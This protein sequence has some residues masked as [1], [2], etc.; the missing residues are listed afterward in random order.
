MSIRHPRSL[1]WRLVTWVAAAQGAMFALLILAMTGVVGALWMRGSISSGIY[2]RS[3]IEALTEAV[4][5]GARGELI[6]RPAPELERLRREIQGF[7]FIVRDSQG[8]EVTEGQAP[9]ELTPL[10][11]GLDTVESAVLRGN[12]GD[13]APSLAI[14]QWIDTAAGRVQMLTGGQGRLLLHQVVA[15]FLPMLYLTLLIIGLMTVATFLVTPFVV[16]RA[17]AGLGRVA[18]EAKRIDITRSGTRLPAVGVPV[19]IVPLVNAV[20]GAL[21]RLDRGYEGHKRFLADAAHELRTPIAILT[22]RISA[23]QPGPEKIR[24]LED[25]TRLTVLT[26]QLLDLQRLD[27]EQASFAPVDLVALAE[28]SVLDL[29]PLAFTAGYEMS[30]EA[31]TGEIRVDGDETALDRALMNLIQNAIDHGGRRGTIAVRVAKAGWIEVCDDG[32]GIPPDQR[33][34]IFEPFHRLRQGGR[35]AGLG[36]DLVRRIMGLHGGRVEVVAGSSAGACIHLIFPRQ[37]SS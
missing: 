3:T 16:Q 5:R 11:K 31:E 9:A 35:G 4:G 17:L 10:M 14:V 26:G 2:E 6:L 30:F 36:L 8:R 1:K 37:R 13:D 19:E 25:M 18:D 20:N 23:L 21:A 32:D 7:W 29:A 24:L 15:A 28:R 12:R 27:R 22:T 33:E 34:Q